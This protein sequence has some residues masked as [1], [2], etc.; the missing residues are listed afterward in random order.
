MPTSAGFLA[1]YFVDVA[2]VS[3]AIAG[4]AVAV[5]TGVGLLGDALLI[6]LLARVPGLRYLRLSAALVAALFP[7]CLL[8]E[9]LALKLAALGA[10]GLLNSGWYAIP[11]A[12]LYAA[13][14]GQSGA[15]LAASNLAGLAG[16]APLAIR[17]RAQVAGLESRCGCCWP[18]RW[19]CW[20][21][22][23]STA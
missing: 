17:R 7:L 9:P 8:A 15:A 19:H 20:S 22:C 6:P 11:M 16:T 13:L 4:L 2:G 21:A 10:L 5:W 14:P 12:Q 18:V 23:P 1:L 3:P